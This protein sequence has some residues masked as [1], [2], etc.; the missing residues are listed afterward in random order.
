[1][2]IIKHLLVFVLILAVLAASPAN[3]ILKG[4]GIDLDGLFDMIPGFGENGETPDDTDDNPEDPEDPD[5]PEPPVTQ[6]D[7]WRNTYSCITVEEALE[8]C[9]ETVSA[10]RYY[11]I[12]T[13]VS[14]DNATFGQMTIE[15]ETGSIMVYGTYSEDGSIR[16][17]AMEE[18]PVSGDTVLI[19]GTLQNYKGE[20]KEVQNA[21]L[22]DFYK[23]QIDDSSYKSATVSEAR[24]AKDGELLKVSGQV[25]CITY[26]FGYAPNGFFIVD[27]KDSIYVYGQ[28]S[29]G[30]VKV[31][32]RVTVLGEK[33][34]WILETEQSNA[35]KFGYGGCNQ[36]ANARVEINDAAENTVSFA[37]V[38]EATLKELME[39]PV[40][41]DFTTQVY[42]VTSYVKKVDGS[43]F[44]NYYFFDI[45]GETG[46]YT[47]TQCSGGDF[48]WVDEFDGKICTVYLSV[49][50]A[51][52]AKSGC[53][54]RLVPLKIV[55]EGYSF[56]LNT[57]PSHVMEY[58]VSG[59]ISSEYTG[60]PELTLNGSVSSELLG[61]ENAIITYSSSNEDVVAFTVNND[62]TVTMN[63]PDYGMAEV[64]ITVSYNGNTATDSFNVTVKEPIAYEALT[65]AEAIAAD[66][67]EK[68]IVKG[69]VGASL[70]NQSGFYLIDESGAIAV[71]MDADKLAELEIGNEIILEAVKYRKYDETKSLHGQTALNE[72]TVLTNLFGKQEYST[73]SFGEITVE[74]FCAFD[75]TV[76]NTTRVYRMSA[77]I[78][79]VGN[80]YYT[81]IVVKNEDESKSITLY[82]AN[83]G[84]YGFLNEFVGQTVTLEIAACDWNQKG[85]KGAVLAVI[86]EDGEKIVNTLNFDI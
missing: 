12:A 82:S 32:Q 43:G 46:T 37:S 13:V 14:V 86:I 24:A 17:D 20:T 21:R 34:Y 4:W 61:F 6:A 35:E 80:A 67:G 77:K 58:Y 53:V 48:S 68:V 40:S 63:C 59:K 41:E 60:D 71:L 5:T 27:G 44:T 78:V 76:D 47:Y 38:P 45:D 72:S 49:I 64:T 11:I 50:N 66:F 19:Y 9:K 83:A 36:L 25:A 81:S 75:N 79:S 2:Y 51:K 30:L 26:A 70:V 55:D 62:G 33:D 85:I 74:E 28:E 54:Y 29:A 56:D 57:V 39:K 22:I 8:L 16:Y 1:M 3:D 10:E 69:I 52:S 73:A 23:A 84:Q 7:I 42:K 31:G 15:D 65:V 18:K